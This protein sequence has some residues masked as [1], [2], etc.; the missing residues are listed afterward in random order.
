MAQLALITGAA[1]RIG[2]AMAL[3]LARSGFS[4]AIQ[5]QSSKAEA[6]N[7]APQVK[8]AQAKERDSRQLLG[9]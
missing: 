3:H 5:Y 7:S 6:E 4:V 8:K 2:K 9:F 1:V